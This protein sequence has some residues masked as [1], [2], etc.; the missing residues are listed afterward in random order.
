M[1]QELLTARQVSERLNLSLRTVWRW[2]RSGELPAPIRLGNARRAPRWLASDI[3]AWL[4]RALKGV[5]G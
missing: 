3:D 4:S 2:S 1:N 5:P